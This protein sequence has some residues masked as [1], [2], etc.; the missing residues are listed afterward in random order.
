[1]YFQDIS[2]IKDYIAYKTLFNALECYRADNC[3][4]FLFFSICKIIVSAITSLLRKSL[5]RE[6]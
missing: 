5:K 6:N 2:Q 4:A 3:E 1:M